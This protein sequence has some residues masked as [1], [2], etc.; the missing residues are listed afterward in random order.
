MKSRAASGDG[1]ID[2]QGPICELWQDALLKPGSQSRALPRVSTL[3][4][5]NANLELHHGQR[6]DVET[7][8]VLVAD[9]ARDVWIG[10]TISDLAELGDDIGIE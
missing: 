7:A 9:P 3:D 2:R 4:A 8:G 5:Q 1:A 6:R 10:T